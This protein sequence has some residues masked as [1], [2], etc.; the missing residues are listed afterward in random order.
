[1]A[2]VA[3]LREQLASGDGATRRDVLRF[4]AAFES[5]SAAAL[6]DLEKLL[7]EASELDFRLDILKV[8]LGLG[9]KVDPAPL[10]RQALVSERPEARGRA[11]S[12]L[13]DLEA[14]QAARFVPEVAK[15]LSDAEARLPALA[16]LEGLGPH[17]RPA[18]PA[19]I[20]LLKDE[21]PQIRA[22][23][24][25]AL[26]DFGLA[27][28]EAREA[29]IGVL[30][31]P[32]EGVQLEAATALLEITHDPS[33]V[34]ERLTRLLTSD[35]SEAREMASRLLAV[36][37]GAG[38]AARSILLERL[39][40]G[41]LEAL[42]ALAALGA[43]AS[44][45]IPLL[46]GLYPQADADVR[47]RMIVYLNLAHPAVPGAMEVVRLGLGDPSEQVFM[48]AASTYYRFTRDASEVLP[49]LKKGL[50]AE[51][52]QA[53][54]LALDLA[55]HL[56]SAAR[57]LAPELVRLARADPEKDIRHLAV[58]ALGVV[59]AGQDVVNQVLL[60]DLRGK[61]ELQHLISGVWGFSA[62][63]YVSQL[64]SGDLERLV[65]RFEELLGPVS[66]D[67]FERSMQV[68]SLCE[69]LAAVGG[70]ARGALPVLEK[71]ARDPDPRVREA[72]R[73]ARTRIRSQTR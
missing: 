54:Y 22:R 8:A 63:D 10:L 47:E 60:E 51:G 61:M 58:Q 21:D 36:F 31:D 33:L 52:M 5:E 41:D 43:S 15:M 34:S 30:K 38:P 49:L 3:F 67:A 37:G 53:R 46:P 40:T 23:A 27:A 25:D 1:V 16:F 18:V 4:L 17:A 57:P 19:V 42:D 66:L 62:E 70:R 11:L 14:E 44:K 72:A 2:A 20:A 28:G 24:A 55:S 48:S 59:G 65:S 13:V 71:A 68:E 6:P 7:G 29:L 26:P 73:E 69:L 64:T 39:K 35:D 32:E 45:V 56:E 50:S 9:S 12:V